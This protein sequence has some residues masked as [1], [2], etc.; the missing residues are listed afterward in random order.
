MARYI[1]VAEN[2]DS[3]HASGIF[4]STDKSYYN[5]FKSKLSVYDK[6]NLVDDV[7]V[8]LAVPKYEQDIDS[9]ADLKDS[10][11]SIKTFKVLTQEMAL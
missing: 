10:K 4:P 11:N 5:K 7:K 3:F 1:S 2:P 6:E 8:G 9:I